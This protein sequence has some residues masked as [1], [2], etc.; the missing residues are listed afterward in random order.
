MPSQADWLKDWSL[1]PPTSVTS[2]AE[3]AP[4]VGAASSAGSS[5][6]SAEGAVS[7]GAVE[8]GVSGVPPH[9]ASMPATRTI[10]R[11]VLSNFVFFIIFSFIAF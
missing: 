8:D 3:N 11:I 2:A 7:A 9:A 6:G 10:A 4:S 5:A 1:I